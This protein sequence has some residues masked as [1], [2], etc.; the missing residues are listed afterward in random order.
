MYDGPRGLSVH[1]ARKSR[2][3][4]RMMEEAYRGLSGDGSDNEHFN[5][6]NDPNNNTTFDRITP[7]LPPPSPPLPG[8]DVPRTRPRKIQRVEIEEVEDEDVATRTRDLRWIEDFAGGAGATFGAAGTIFEEIRSEQMKTN[9]V[10]CTPFEDEDEWDL[11]RWLVL[12]GTSLAKVDEFLRLP[13]VRNKLKLP[14]HNKR[15]YLKYVDA[16]PKGPGW[17]WTGLSVTGNLK[18]ANGD[19]LKEVLDVW[20]RDP[21]EVVRDLIGNP[22]FKEFMSYAP[23]RVYRDEEA[24]NREY[25]ES[26]T[27]DWWWEKQ[28]NL[29]EGATI[30]PVIIA[31]DETCLTTFSGDK[32]AWPVYLS[33]GN[34]DKSVRR[35]PS[36]HA[37]VLIGYL[38]VTKLEIFTKEERSTHSHQI[39]HDAMR[40]L[41]EPLV[42]A[43]K[44]GVFMTCADGFIR[45]VFPLVA[46]YIADYPEQCLVACVKSNSCPCCDV[47]P[48]RRGKEPTHSQWRDPVATVK[49]IDDETSGYAS[50][51]FK[52]WNLRPINPFWRDLP[53]CNINRCLTPDI[54]HQLH[55]GLFHDHAVEWGT[56]SMEVSGGKDAQQREIDARYKSMTPHPTLRHF[57]RGISLTSQWT[58][59]EFKNMEKVFLGVL[60]GATDPAVIRTLRGVLDFI[61]LSRLEIHT[62]ESLA[63]LNDAWVTIH[64]NKKI[65]EDLE[66]RKHFNIPKFHNIKHY[67][68]HFRSR[69]TADGFNS[70]LSERLHI[71]CA[72]MGYRASNRH[73][74]TR[75]MISW[76]QRRDAVYRFDLYLEWIALGSLR[77]GSED[78]GES[79]LNEDEV[80]DEEDIDSDNEKDGNPDDSDDGEAEFTS[81]RTPYTV[82]K[83][84]T[85]VPVSSL[86]H[87]HHAHHFLFY[88]QEFMDKNHMT[89]TRLLDEDSKISIWTRAK[90]KLRTLP[91]LAGDANHYDTI[92]ASKHV[93]AKRDRNRL[94][95]AEKPARFST[96]MVRHGWKEGENSTVW[97]LNP[98]FH[99]Q[100][101]RVR[102]IF[103][104]P[105][106]LGTY[107]EPLAFL[108]LFRPLTTNP[109]PDLLMHKVAISTRSHQKVSVIVPLSHIKQTCHLIPVFGRQISPLWTS[110]TIL[111][112]AS[113]FFLNPYLR[114]RDFLLFR[115]WPELLNSN[116][117][118]MSQ[119]H[120]ILEGAAANVD[121]ATSGRPELSR[122]AQEDLDARGFHSGHEFMA[123]L[124]SG[125]SMTDEITRKC[126]D[127]FYRK[128]M[129][130][131]QI[132]EERQGHNNPLSSE[133]L[134]GFLAS[135]YAA[136]ERIYRHSRILRAARHLAEQDRFR[137]HR[138]LTK[139][140]AALRHYRKHVKRLRRI[141]RVQEKVHRRELIQRAALGNLRTG[142]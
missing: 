1:Y 83:R 46:A 9:S 121:Q 56:K 124:W 40:I 35:K 128:Q 107:P 101:A 67:L 98:F 109:S 82:A 136:F 26:C 8:S 32:K 5:P 70:E 54:H 138:V 7:P 36:T 14:C 114:L 120:T 28:E 115:Y 134:E 110:S 64:L 95:T 103:K 69:G 34:I 12:S 80:D 51:N 2:C 59:K 44:D 20:H 63:A 90:L 139:K 100:V 125:N 55:K 102:I 78:V 4:E 72:K 132:K 21:V 47:D 53:H 86:Q 3:S 126:D 25:S 97:G 111:D 68:D 117:T 129:K 27:C 74:Y 81:G 89:T 23:Q 50:P 104:F 58:G 106:E 37:M 42:K 33:I 135:A 38:P 62:D 52:T 123:R 112:Q 61:Y 77:S 31:S 11:I 118:Y 127:Y 92:Y 30:A 84:T 24:T 137:L 73:N 71:D 22:A 91:T 65:F 130:N 108:D 85:L 113:S 105:S 75:Q 16:L 96:V 45:R 43:G 17:S 48:Q 116:A 66:I 119:T 76:L 142:T 19:Y 15:T 60:A 140:T 49:A 141:L 39:F 57:N 13:V 94:P 93:P 41:L 87:D 131:R 79:A 122:T 133:E 29:P 6:A 10:P 18:D 99:L 88:L